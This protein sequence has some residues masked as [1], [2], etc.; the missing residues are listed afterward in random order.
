MN[1]K[2]LVFGV[3][4]IIIFQ[5]DSLG[6]RQTAVLSG[7]F[8]FLH[9]NDSVII[10]TYKY[11]YPF[12]SAFCKRLIIRSFGDS[13]LHKLVIENNSTYIDINFPHHPNNSFRFYP[14]FAG[15]RIKI[16]VDSN[17]TY[18]SG[19]GYGTF[20]IRSEIDSIRNQL[21]AT[22][23]FDFRNFKNVELYMS[24]LDSIRSECLK[25]LI[26]SKELLNSY[27]YNLLLS[28]IFLTI[29]LQKLSLVK[30]VSD[31]NSDTLPKRTL[32]EFEKCFSNDTLFNFQQKRRS[33]ELELSPF[34]S[35]FVI[36]N[37]TVNSFVLSDKL[38]SVDSL[39]K[40]ICSKFSGVMRE[41][42]LTQ[43]LYDYRISSMANYSEL[44]DRGISKVNTPEFRTLLLSLKSTFGKGAAAYNFNLK[45]TSGKFIRLTDFKNKVMVMDFWF[46]GCGNCRLLQPYLYKVERKFEDDSVVFLSV[47]I[48]KERESWI[49]S[50]M[51]GQY[52]SPFT[53]NLYTNGNGEKNPI[54][55]KYKID[56]YPTVLLIGKEGQICETPKDARLDDGKDLE[57]KIKNALDN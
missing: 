49:R 28:D 21:D 13:I 20:K 33:K 30:F 44:L 9:D 12:R 36:L 32:I 35:S 54:I 10:T 57:L 40:Y 47:C 34:Y 41:K 25:L 39:F 51:G 43:I 53:V 19:V 37:Y 3:L 4:L 18:F 15:D 24:A 50:I 14:I 22:Q 27:R 23:R 26:G 29:E 2:F 38:F 48:D 6:Q 42:L 5:F 1:F 7:K 55:T 56:S 8:Y 11:G 46:T 16:V 45:D 31:V 52:T 17:K